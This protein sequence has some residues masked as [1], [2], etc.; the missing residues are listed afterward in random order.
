MIRLKALLE[1]QTELHA[2]VATHFD[3]IIAGY[4]EWLSDH[5]ETMVAQNQ[6]DS[7]QAFDRMQ[8]FGR[9]SDDPAEFVS[10][11]RRVFAKSDSDIHTFLSQFI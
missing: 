11:V 5:L 3:S 1:S 6:L 8:L 4:D 2:W 9:C 10:Y 7:G